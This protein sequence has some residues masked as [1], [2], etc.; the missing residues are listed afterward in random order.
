[1]LKTR[2]NKIANILKDIKV[3]KC[4]ITLCKLEKIKNDVFNIR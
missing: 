1:M 3:E 4:E 2:K